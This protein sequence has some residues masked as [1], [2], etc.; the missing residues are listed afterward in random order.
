MAPA[1][2]ASR[3][4]S[5]DGTFDVAIIGAGVIGCALARRFT[6]EGARAV[7]I[8]KGTQR[9]TSRMNSLVLVFVFVISE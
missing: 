1:G 7:L 3:H 5:G 6:L 9:S 4:G 2:D 8:E